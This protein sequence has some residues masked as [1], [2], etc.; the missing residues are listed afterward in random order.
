[1]KRAVLIQLAAAMAVSLSMVAAADDR[2]TDK[3]MSRAMELYKLE[4]GKAP[5][6]AT[7]ASDQDVYDQVRKDIARDLKDIRSAL[8]AK[9]MQAEGEEVGAGGMRSFQIKKGVLA[10]SL[11]EMLREPNAAAD[12]SY[13]LVW[14]APQYMVPETFDVQAGDSLGALEKVLEAYNRE[15]VPLEAILF[16]GNGVIEVTLGGFRQRSSVATSNVAK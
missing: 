5:N 12:G 2:S 16:S 14:R 9:G 8:R 15:G 4:N 10:N 6:E 7:A 13:K 3:R 1:M 11:E